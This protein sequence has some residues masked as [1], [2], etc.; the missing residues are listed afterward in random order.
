MEN[1]RNRIGGSHYSGIAA[2]YQPD[3][4][5]LRRTVSLVVLLLT[6]LLIGLATRAHADENSAGCQPLRGSFS[7]PS[8]SHF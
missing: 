8:I 3:Q 7:A 4:G 1:Q 2:V 5:Q 6:V